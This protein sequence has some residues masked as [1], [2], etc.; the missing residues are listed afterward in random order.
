MQC[1][2][3]LGSAGRPLPGPGNAASNFRAHGAF[4]SHFTNSPVPVQYHVA[5]PRFWPQRRCLSSFG[6]GLVSKQLQSPL[7]PASR[8]SYMRRR[9][10][11][12]LA[13]NVLPCSTCRDLLRSCRAR[14]P[15]TTTSAD[16]P[17]M[18]S[19]SQGAE[20]LIASLAKAQ[21]E[22]EWVQNALEAEF[23]RRHK[24]GREANPYSILTRINKL[25]RCGACTP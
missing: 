4:V 10:F 3:P 5:S 14:G 13:R 25:R 18:A 1:C 6:P 19:L 23:A 24:D 2:E 7:G 20:S 21:A 12:Q 8:E 17:P 22:L 9:S 16:Q 15:A 11:V